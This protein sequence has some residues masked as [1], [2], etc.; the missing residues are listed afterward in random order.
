MLLRRDDSEGE[1]SDGSKGACHVIPL[2]LS[3]RMT[4]NGTGEESYSIWI[5]E[6]DDEGAETVDVMVRMDT[7]GGGRHMRSRCLEKGVR[8]GC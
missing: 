8:D 6:A 1:T 7:S 3:K 5:D 4:G 2:G